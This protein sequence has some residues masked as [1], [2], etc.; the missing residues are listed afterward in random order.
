ME[1]SV[2]LAEWIGGRGTGH[3][4]VDRLEAMRASPGLL[5]VGLES[6]RQDRCREG[7]WE[8]NTTA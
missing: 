7:R 3:G 8:L 4:G 6:P 1:R 2:R 5:V